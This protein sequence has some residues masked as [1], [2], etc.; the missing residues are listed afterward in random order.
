MAAL[1]RTTPIVIKV[2]ETASVFFSLPVS[3]IISDRTNAEVVAARRGLFHGL[4][5]S[6]LFT[7]TTLSR[8]FFH[9]RD[10]LSNLMRRVNQMLVAPLNDLERKTVELSA[11]VCAQAKASMEA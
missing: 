5:S 4:L 9:D 3:A 10:G 2:L 1:N 11:L 7:T 6:G 8:C